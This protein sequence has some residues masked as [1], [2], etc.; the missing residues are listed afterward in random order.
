ML[1]ARLR[2]LIDRCLDGFGAA[3]ARRGVTANAVT[4]TAFVFGLGAMAALALRWDLLAL[5]LFAVNRIGDGLDGAV[6]RHAGLSDLGGFLDI[7]LDFVVYAGMVF[8]FVLGRPDN[9][10]A[11]AFLLFSFMGT[12]SSFLAYAILAAKRNVTT[13]LRGRK[14]LYYLGGLTEGT[15]TTALL[16]AICLVPDAFPW[17]AWGFGAACWLTTATRIV[18]ARQAFGAASSSPPS[19]GG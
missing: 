11:G 1:D 19:P 13:S 6:A 15:E 14:S 10:L 2:P 3:A 12:A 17:L 9:A 7:V 8:A 18:A 4:V 5:A 16:V